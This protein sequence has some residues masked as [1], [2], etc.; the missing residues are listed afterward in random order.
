MREKKKT[1]KAKKKE[2]S[3]DPKRLKMCIRV[4]GEW[5]Q[6]GASRLGSRSRSL[7]KAKNSFTFKKGRIFSHHDQRLKTLLKK[8]R[9]EG[10][11]KDAQPVPK[12]EV[13]KSHK[14]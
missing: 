6:R 5:D 1:K 12:G 9:G 7:K 13:N 3:L 8:S 14:L 2:K 11:K 10:G 4:G